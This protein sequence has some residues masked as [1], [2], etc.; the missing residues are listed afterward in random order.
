M[1]GPRCSVAARGVVCADMADAPRPPLSIDVTWHAPPPA[2]GPAT[3]SA[4]P[5]ALRPYVL[6]LYSDLARHVDL[7]RPAHSDYDA[8]RQPGIGIPV[9]LGRPLVEVVAELAGAP[10]VEGVAELAEA[11]AV[12]AVQRVVVMLLDGGAFDEIATLRAPVRQLVELASVIATGC[13]FCRWS[14]IRDGNRSS[15][16]RR[17]SGWRTCHRPSS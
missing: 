13:C 4:L 10:M 11:P 7:A 2:E 12:D 15:R 5:D 1:R 8:V 16:R 9:H 17:P 14:S 3:M 6:G